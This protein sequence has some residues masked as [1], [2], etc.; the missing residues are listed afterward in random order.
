MIWT[1]ECMD[2]DVKLVLVLVSQR[3]YETKQRYVDLE[4]ECI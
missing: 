2:V 3:Q 4:H 1:D